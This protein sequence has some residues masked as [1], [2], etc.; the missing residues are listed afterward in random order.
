MGLGK[1]KVNYG[2]RHDGAVRLAHKTAQDASMEAASDT[3][4]G[5]T[6]HGEEL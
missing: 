6:I 1:C 5:K 3:F 4:E 2:V